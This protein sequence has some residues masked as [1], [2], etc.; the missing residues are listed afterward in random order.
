[1]IKRAIKLIPI[2]IIK[3]MIIIAIVLIDIRATKTEVPTTQKIKN[4]ATVKKCH[5]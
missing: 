1:M 3:I 5:H 4:A 2:I